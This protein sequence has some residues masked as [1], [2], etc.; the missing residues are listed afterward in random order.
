MG[1]LKILGTLMGR[2]SFE[3]FLLQ[4]DHIQ[5][6]TFTLESLSNIESSIDVQQLAETLLKSMTDHQQI[7]S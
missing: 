2:I 7:N 3:E 1:G 4:G 5:Q 6:L